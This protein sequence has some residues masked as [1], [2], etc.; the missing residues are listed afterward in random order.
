[1]HNGSDSTAI[2]EEK[3]PIL[4]A[5]LIEPFKY[6]FFHVVDGDPRQ[7]HKRQIEGKAGEKASPNV[8]RF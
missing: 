3:L 4:I 5:S 2:T 7:P 1:L 8:L 6:P